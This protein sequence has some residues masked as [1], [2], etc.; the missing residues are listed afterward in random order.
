MNINGIEIQCQNY[1]A[2]GTSSTK[3]SGSPSTFDSF[4]KEIVNWEKQFKEAKEKEQENDRNGSIQMSEEHWRNIMKKVDNAIDTLKDNNKEQEQEE[5]VH[6][7]EDTVAA[8]LLRHKK[9]IQ[10]FGPQLVHSSGYNAFLPPS[11][12]RA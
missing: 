6:L 11:G 8:S 12:K 9:Y 7:G 3:S 10:S 1:A 5:K 2:S 4:L